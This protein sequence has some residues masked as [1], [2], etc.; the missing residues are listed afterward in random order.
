MTV[1]KNSALILVAKIGQTVDFRCAHGGF[2]HRCTLEGW[3]R[4]SLTDEDV[5]W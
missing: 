3:E 1:W 2:V 5:L 4:G